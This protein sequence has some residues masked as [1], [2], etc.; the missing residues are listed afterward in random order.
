MIINDFV[1]QQHPG[2]RREVSTAG[3]SAA[4]RFRSDIPE[5]Y[6]WRLE[7]IYT[8]DELWRQDLDIV[9]GM[10]E[11]VPSWTGRLAESGATLH[12]CFEHRDQTSILFYKLYVYAHLR[13]DEDNRKSHYQEMT[14][15]I[16]ALA[17]VYS[18][19]SSYITPEILAISDDRLKE[20][21]A[22][23]EPLRVYE[24]HLDQLRR[25]REHILSPAEERLM[26]L[27]GHITRGPNLVFQMLDDADLKFGEVTD[28]KGK[29]IVLTKQRYYSLLESKNRAVRKEASEVFVAGYKVF[30]N[31]L[32]ANLSA[33][34]YKDLFY[35]KARK[36]NSCLE[37]ALD[38]D[39]I[40]PQTYHN[41][42]STVDAHLG[43]LQRYARLRRQALGVDRLHNYDM[44]VPLAPEVEIKISYN[45]AVNQIVEGLW[46]LGDDYINDLKRAFTDGWID[47]YETEGKGSGAYSWSVYSIHPYVLLNYNDTLH[48]MFTVAHEMG[49]AMHS[50]YSQRHQP[51]IYSGH[52][53][54][55]AE[56]AST[57]NE[58]LLMHYLLD[59]VR[60]KEEK[61]YLLSYYLQQIVGT[62]FTQA[63]YSQF[64]DQVHRDVEA[65]RPLSADSLRRTYRALYEKFWGGRS[66]A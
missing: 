62:F 18:E 53:I 20:M 41:L 52:S 14:D 48:N 23:Y 8:S 38:A 32:G 46:P 57:T 10:I 9:K 58:E 49:H 28:D 21:L 56:V 63:M 55:T 40:P 37:A 50:F 12:Q 11:R 5:K 22:E 34:I 61:A 43:V 30:H 59:R 29:R 2:L 13:L 54:F 60:A 42:L 44:Y 51:Y 24:H 17:T 33:S 7:D 25:M 1:L 3:G 35:T 4:A 15:E 39:N 19:A 45:D 64:E 26:A 36:Y 47:V 6:R 31:T 66:G 16:A 65:G 27:A